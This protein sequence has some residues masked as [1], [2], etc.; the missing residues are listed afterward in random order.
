MARERR[1]LLT[2]NF[3]RWAAGG[4]GNGGA[5]HASAIQV[6][7]LATL[8]TYAQPQPLL[9]SAKPAARRRPFRHTRARSQTSASLAGRFSEKFSSKNI[10]YFSLSAAAAAARGDAL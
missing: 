5:G 6:P 2:R 7:T 1:R 9:L 3:R 8:F 4:D 10:A